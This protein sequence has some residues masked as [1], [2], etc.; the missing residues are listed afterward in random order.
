MLL[1]SVANEF[2]DFFFSKVKF[3]FPRV[4]RSVVRVSGSDDCNS[5]FPR[6]DD[7]DG[8]LISVDAGRHYRRYKET[9]DERQD[10]YFTV[11]GIQRIAAR[12]R[13]RLRSTRMESELLDYEHS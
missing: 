3:H 8:T 13:N 2:R 7:E 5:F 1:H 4:L 11:S 10:L 6:F 9:N 12:V